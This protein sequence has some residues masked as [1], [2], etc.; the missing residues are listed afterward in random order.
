VSLEAMM[1]S[2]TIDVKEDRYVI[3][4]VFPG[5]FLHADMEDEVHM[6]H[7]G[8]IAE[9][10]IKPEPNLYRRHIWHNQKG[11]PMLYVKLEKALY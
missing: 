4:M 7:E 10:I 2:C 9:L 8:N 6:L 1:L 3:V 5:A 11:K